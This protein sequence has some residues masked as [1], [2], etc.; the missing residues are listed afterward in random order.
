[1]FLWCTEFAFF[2]GIIK[3]ISRT[4]RCYCLIQGSNRLANMMLL[5]E[6]VRIQ[7]Q[8]Q[9]LV[10]ICH[11]VFAKA[12]NIIFHMLACGLIFGSFK[13]FVSQVDMHFGAIDA[14]SFV[15][16]IVSTFASLS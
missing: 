14:F 4:C 5:H 3:A 11:A 16:R 6:N 15:E 2:N 7:P 13:I 10:R 1:M 8:G 9:G 12:G